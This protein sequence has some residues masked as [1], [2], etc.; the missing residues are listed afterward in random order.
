[1]YVRDHLELSRWLTKLIRDRT[2]WDIKI[3]MIGYYIDRKELAPGR[4]RDAMGRNESWKRNVRYVRCVLLVVS[5][6]IF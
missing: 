1:M 6:S 2:W 3:Q 5:V 4:V